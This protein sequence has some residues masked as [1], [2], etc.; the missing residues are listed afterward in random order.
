MKIIKNFSNS[1]KICVAL[2]VLT[3][4][5]KGVADNIIHEGVSVPGGFYLG[6][7]RMK[8]IK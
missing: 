8:S 2:L 7:S 3:A 6:M 4:T 1:L 5:Q